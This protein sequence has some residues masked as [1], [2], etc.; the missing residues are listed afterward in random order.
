MKLTI[1]DIILVNRFQYHVMSTSNIGDS[2]L[3]LRH[4]DMIT[5]LWSMR[6]VNK[7]SI[8]TSRTVP[9]GSSWCD[10]YSLISSMLTSGAPEC[11]SVTHGSSRSDSTHFHSHSLLQIP[12]TITFLYILIQS[13]VGNRK[14]VGT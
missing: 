2:M 1:V 5:K 14:V 7:V 4:R 11:R 9:R 10:S 13:K 12:K 6:A 3:S 8:K